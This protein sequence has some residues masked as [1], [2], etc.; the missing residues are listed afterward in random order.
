MIMPFENS[1][2]N[3]LQRLVGDCRDLLTREF[4]AQLQEL[5]GIYA[6]EER[7]LVLEKLTTL[8]DEKLRVASMLRE[9][10]NHLAS[11]G[12]GTPA[13]I[14]EAIKRV[15]REQAFTVLNRF[16][17]LRMA[18]ERGIIVE[19]VGGGLNSKGFKTYTE[20]A[21]SGLGSAYERYRVFLRC[22]FY[23]MATDLGVLFDRRSPY[24][25]LFPRENVLLEVFELLNAPEVKALWKEDETLGWIYQYFNDPIERKKMREESAAPRNSRELAVRNQFFTPRYVVEFLTDNTLG[26]IWYEMIGSATSLKEKCRYLVRRPNEIFLKPGEVAPGASEAGQSLAGRTAQATRLHPAPSAQRPAHDPYA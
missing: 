13:A 14:C 11:G 10:I 20:V 23:E 9:R 18:E 21:H 17:A 3:R 15:L 19:S 2:R 8:D 6:G 24:G 16:A 4:D 26:R 22:I 7:V 5:Y 12:G 25:L 1:T